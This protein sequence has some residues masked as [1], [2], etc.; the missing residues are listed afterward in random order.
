[1][2]KVEHL[3][4]NGIIRIGRQVYWYRGEGRDD[5]LDRWLGIADRRVSVGA[6]ELCCRAAL[7]GVGFGRAAGML[8]RLGQI[9]VS[10]E[11]LREIV[12]REGRAVLGA[13][14]SWQLGP[15]WEA[16]DCA[17]SEGGPTRVMVG[18]DGVMVPLITEAEKQKRRAKVARKRSRRKAAG[19]KRRRG[20]RRRGS[21]QAY[22]EFKIGTLYD[23]SR[24][25][26]YAFGT[27][28]NHEVL[29]RQL[30]REASKVKIDE[31]DEKVSVS[32][33]AEW[34]RRQLQTR[35]PMLDAMVLDFYHLA[36]HVGAAARTCFGEGSSAAA[37]WS[38]QLLEA[39]RQEGPSAMLVEVEQTLRATRSPPKR[40]ALKDL[41][42]YVGKRCDMLDYPGFR[43]KGWDIGSGPTEAFCKTLTARLKGSGMRWDKL[44]A[45]AM[46]AL[47]AVE[48]S[49]LWK[50]YWAL[51]LSEAA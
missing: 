17:V 32:D 49:N 46:M 30:R 15:D 19:G 13:T 36:E 2:Q 35:L 27:S 23:E 4:S 11:R 26:Q 16:K 41:Q 10:K 47:A 48:H 28:G 33:G 42:Q 45:E 25:H 14:K 50:R 43:A 31:A 51:Q 9:R 37:D 24:Q 39:V 29:G 40:K 12:E 6:R 34:I 22:K 20:R 5:R 21:D 38:R 8:E 1:V 7:G 44:N 3:S 18:A